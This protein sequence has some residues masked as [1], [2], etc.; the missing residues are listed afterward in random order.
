MAGIDCNNNS[1]TIDDITISMLGRDGNGNCSVRLLEVVD[2]NAPYED[3]S[4]N[5]LSAL[6]LIQLIADVD[7]NGKIA[8]RVIKGVDNGDDCVN[9]S[10]SSEGLKDLILHDVIGLAV[11]GL[12]ALRITI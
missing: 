3:C 2:G 6:E 5:N 10:N 7:G 1:L 11:D 9:C 4:L 8:L 12:P